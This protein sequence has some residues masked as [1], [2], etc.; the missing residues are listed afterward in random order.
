MSRKL[1][2]HRIVGTGAFVVCVPAPVDGIGPVLYFACARF[3]AGHLSYLSVQ[4]AMNRGSCTPMRSFPTATNRGRADADAPKLK[5]LVIATQKTVIAARISMALADVGFRVAAL[6]PHGHPV[7][8]SRKIQD[9]FLYHT[10]PQLKSTVRPI[11]RCSPALL[12]CADD[13]AV[14]ELQALH[15][16]TAASDDKARRH[17]SKLIELSI[18]PATSFAP[19]VSKSEFLARVEIEGSRFPRTIVVPATRAFESVPELIYPIVVKADQ[20]YGGRCVRIINS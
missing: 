7:R 20:S 5:I 17:I 14:R 4:Q 9:H 15:Q 19:I 2:A 6:T 12:V 18:G 8:R 3:T 11:E 13:L 10:R 16:R 1:S